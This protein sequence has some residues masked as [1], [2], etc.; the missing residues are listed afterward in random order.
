MAMG[1]VHYIHY[2]WSPEV[3]AA[4]TQ[5]PS[6]FLSW[7]K[8][9]KRV[10]CLQHWLLGIMHGVYNALLLLV[11]CHTLLPL[12]LKCLPIGW[13]IFSLFFWVMYPLSSL[14]LVEK[15]RGVSLAL[16]KFEFCSKSSA[17][18][19]RFEVRRTIASNLSNYS[20]IFTLSQV[21]IMSNVIKD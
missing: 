1:G 13:L 10:V 3:N 16:V 21:K 8:R 18:I 19:L 15:L 9:A 11:A 5:L 17:K 4:S 12:V 7:E 6:P 20:N 14:I 2:A